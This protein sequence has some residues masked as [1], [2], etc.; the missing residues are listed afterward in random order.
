[1]KTIGLIGGT[2]WVSTKDYYKI[3]NEIVRKKLGKNHSAKCIL[4]S[5]DFQDSILDKNWNERTIIFIDIAKKLEKFGADFII[6]C[7]NTMHKFADKIQNKISITIL[8]IVDVTAK[9][10]KEKKLK[11]V[12]LLGTKYTMREE[13]YINRIQEKFGIEI[14]VPTKNEQEYMHDVI[15]EE[16]AKEIINPNSKKKYIE[17]CNNLILKGVE[18]IILGC[19]EIPL[20][21]N[22]DDFNIPIFDT[23]KIHAEAAVE[24]AL[25]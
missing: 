25:E 9:K 22:E 3:I 2:T 24:F 4:Y 14:I 15:I 19:T 13:F 21:I 10:I 11:R 8:H 7:A 23:T 1:M 6:I 16:L 20:L 12:G 18:G 5:V 17:I